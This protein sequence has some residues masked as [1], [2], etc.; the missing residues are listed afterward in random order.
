ML[1]SWSNFHQISHDGNF[2]DFG[3]FDKCIKIHQQLR[4]GKLI[5]GQ[6][7]LIQFHSIPSLTVNHGHEVSSFN[8]GWRK[9]NSRFGGAVCLPLSC[10]SNIVQHLLIDLLNGSDYRLS[11]DYDEK[12]YCKATETY[13]K[14]I[15][16]RLFAAVAAVLI[17]IA[18]FSTFYDLKS[19]I[20]NN[21]NQIFLSFSIHTNFKA[22]CNVNETGSSNDIKFLHG[23]R[24]M[25]I[26]GIIFFHIHFFREQFPVK[27]PAQLSK[28]L[29]SDYSLLVDRFALSVETFFVISGMLITRE[30]L[31]AFDW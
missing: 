31:K 6:Y 12:N 14:T 23:I 11:S 9:L 21:R 28:F 25:S 15:Y 4:T 20:T 30:L 29:A 16:F 19:C 2:Y 5:D 18:A 13:Y 3:D 22:L 27:N 10:A 24:S 8:S 17:I 1:A 26:F 7:C